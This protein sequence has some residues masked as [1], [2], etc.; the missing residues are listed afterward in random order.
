MSHNHHKIHLLRASLI[1]V[2]GLLIVG[3]VAYANRQ[4]LRDVLARWL[5]GPLPPAESWGDIK[6]KPVGIYVPPEAVNVPVPI[7]GANQPPIAPPTVPPPITSVPVTAEPLPASI[8]LKV[9]FYP[10]TPLQVWDKIH[11]DTCEEASMLMIRGFLAGTPAPSKEEM[12][13]QLLDIVDYEN[14]TLG[15]FESTDAD[16]TVQVMR[17]YLGLKAATVIT[18][19]S[20][21]DIKRELAEGR[22][23]ILPTS[24]KAL[25]NPNFRSGGPVYHMLVVKGYVKGKFITNDPGTRKGADYVYAEQLLWNAIADW[26][27]S[28]VDATKKRMIIVQ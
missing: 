7:P 17:D 18:P 28:G 2:F 15:Y 5:Q 14:K 10:Q 19:A 23:V 3:G 12:D 20:I 9:P 26:T 8:N 6:A 27:G 11:E 22:P 24:G 25:K 16:T 4:D 13:R 1:V 21:D